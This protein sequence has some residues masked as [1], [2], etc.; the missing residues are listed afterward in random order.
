MNSI[1]YPALVGLIAGIIK[2]WQHIP[3]N[4][5]VVVMLLY[6]NL[7]KDILHATGTVSF[8]AL[9]LSLIYAF[10]TYNKCIN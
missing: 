8:I 3:V 2:G 10:K 9:G 4:H 7:T 1:I 5:L 6:F